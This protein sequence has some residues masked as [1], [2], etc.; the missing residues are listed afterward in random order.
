MSFRTVFIT[1]FALGAGILAAAGA[2]LL[3]GQASKSGEPKMASIVVTAADVPRGASLSSEM[4]AVRQWPQGYV[5][6]GAITSL[7]EALDRTA[8]VPLVKGEPI[9]ENKLT[10]RGAGRGMAALVPRGMRAV[11]IQTPNISTGVAGF[12]LPG[13]HVDVLLTMSQAGSQDATGGGSTVALLQNV[14]ILA[15]DQR[16]EAPNENRV[17]PKDLRSVTLLV[18]PEQASRLE[19]G[20]NKGTLHLSLRNP[21]DIDSAA[22]PPV[23]L[24]EL[25]LQQ[26]ETGAVVKSSLPGEPQTVKRIR[27]AIQQIRTIRGSQN[28]VVHL[29]RLQE[30]APEQV[31]DASS[32]GENAHSDPSLV[33]AEGS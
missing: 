5:P 25:R 27:P 26:S 8:W 9:M 1:I 7:A 31:E 3:R 19:L 28:G 11:T 29:S 13:N 6:E 18:S 20:Q 33:R 23:T 15:V 24:A 4:L 10:A 21:E 30:P 17:D 14:E 32:D 16:I 22:V 2:Y 12:I